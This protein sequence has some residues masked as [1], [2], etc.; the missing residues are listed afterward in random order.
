MFIKFLIVIFTVFII[1][2]L[3]S[4]N[5]ILEGMKKGKK[6]KAPK[7]FRKAKKKAKKAKEAVED[8]LED[9]EEAAEDAVNDAGE[10]LPTAAQLPRMVNEL[11]TQMKDVITQVA[12]LS[13]KTSEETTADAEGGG[14]EDEGF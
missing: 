12:V 9:G 8:A 4:N 3:F 11:Q 6:K 1:Y 14:G 7:G 13:R 2:L 10:P 5:T